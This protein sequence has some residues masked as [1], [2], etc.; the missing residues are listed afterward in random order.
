MDFMAIMCCCPRIYWGILWYTDQLQTSILRKHS[1]WSSLH[2]LQ[3]SLECTGTWSASDN[4]L[5]GSN[6][7]CEWCLA[8]P[9]LH[10][11]LVV[12]FSSPCSSYADIIAGC[13][14]LCSIDMIWEYRHSIL[15]SCWFH[16]NSI[17]ML[18]PSHTLGSI[19]GYYT[20][21][22]NW[23]SGTWN[24][25]QQNIWHYYPPMN[26]AFVDL[27]KISYCKAH[28]LDSDSSVLLARNRLERAG[29]LQV[30]YSTIT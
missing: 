25:I 3:A 20:Q 19:L 4:R 29:F 30:F 7:L 6:G 27:G 17:W 1:P 5:I 16:L 23:E 11:H 9:R 12:Y 8:P 24:P 18:P 2:D 10:V 15:L 21:S 22:W 26:W 13:I 14:L 28:T